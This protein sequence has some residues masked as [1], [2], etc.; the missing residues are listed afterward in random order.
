MKSATVKTSGPE[1]PK[2][3]AFVFRKKEDN[4]QHTGVEP[5]FSQSRPFFPAV[6]RTCSCVDE[7]SVQ[8]QEFP[9]PEVQRNC[10]AEKDEK[11]VQ[12]MSSQEEENAVQHF[13]NEAAESNVQTR[14]IVNEPGD[15]YEQ[16]ANTISEKVMRSETPDREKESVTVSPYTIRRSF[17]DKEKTNCS[18]CQELKKPLV[19]RKEVNGKNYDGKAAPASVSKVI[20]SGSGKSLDIDT[21][22]Y[23]ENRMGHDFSGVKI[24]TDA[25]A[26]ESARAIQAL[27]YTA[28]NHIV[29]N[30]GQYAPATEAG[31]MLLAH[32]LVH[33]IQQGEGVKRQ[34]DTQ[35]KTDAATGSVCDSNTASAEQGAPV[36]SEVKTEIP[37]NRTG[38]KKS[39]VA[40][41]GPPPATPKDQ[42]ADSASEGGNTDEKKPLDSP[43]DPSADPA[44]KEL[45]GDTKKAKK[46]QD[47][48]EPEMAIAEEAMMSAENQDPGGKLENDAKK[49]LATDEK[50][51]PSQ[52][53]NKAA[54]KQ[55]IKDLIQQGLPD[56]EAAN[57][58]FNTNNG[59]GE[60][61]DKSKGNV[62]QSE[63]PTKEALKNTNKA[64]TGSVGN[65]TSLIYKKEVIPAEPESPGKK[66][67]VGSSERAVP[68]P[69]PEAEVQLDEA[70]NADSLDKAMEDENLKEFNTKLTNNQ[71]AD[72]NEPEFMETLA[73][74]QEA[75]V[76]LCQVPTMNREAEAKA[77][78]EESGI[79]QGA[80][81]STM[82]GKFSERGKSIDQVNKG[83]DESKLKDEKMLADYYTKIAGIYDIAQKDVNKRMELLD[84][85]VST[86]FEEAMTSA[87]DIFKSRVKSR[88]D[89]YYGVGVFDLSDEGA[90]ALE[91][92]NNSS[93]EGKVAWLRLQ[94][95]RFPQESDTYKM[96]DS[97]IKE[98]ESGKMETIVD[99]VFREEKD[100]FTQSLDT[101]LDQI[102]DIIEKTF[103]DCKAIITK[104]KEDIKCA[105]QC[106]PTHLQQE[107]TERTD[108][109]ISKF[110]DLDQVLTDKQKD[111]QERL[112]KDYV[113]NVKKLKE[114]FE[115]IRE[116]SA[117]PWWKKAWNA[118][119]KVAMI[120]YDLGKLLLKVLIKAA[121]AIGDIVAHPIRFIGN[122]ISAVGKGFSNFV[123]NIGTHLENIIFKLILGT[124]PP[125][126][127]MPATWDAKGIFS[128]ALDILGLTKENI[129]EKA[130]VKL[131][132]PVVNALEDTFDLF[133]LF[134]KEGF[135]GLWQHIKEKIGDLKDQV[136][137]QIKDYFKDSII[138]AAVKF[139]L[140]CLTPVSGFIKACETLIN[141]ALFFIKNLENILKL[142]D[143]ILDSFIDISKGKVESA[144]KRVEGALADILLI[145]IKFLA[146]LVGINL[147]KI[148]AKI[149]KLFNA[150]RN[151]I[152]RAIT[153]LL[154]K[155]MAFAQ[156]TGLIALVKKGKAK[157]EQGKKWA[158]DKG[159][160][161]VKKG[162]EK[163]KAG[164]ASAKDKIMGW[165]GL[166]KKF[167]AENG[168][169]HELYFSGKGD[170]A[171][172]TMASNKPGAY[173]KWV[174]NIKV[175]T[176]NQAGLARE[177]KKDKAIEVAKEIDILK[178][179][180]T[181]TDEEAETQAADIR[182]K[183]NELSKLT[184]ALMIGLPVCSTDGNGIKF[185]NLSKGGKYGTSM[186]AKQ[187]TKNKMP[188]G[189]VPSVSGNS[190]FNIINQRRHGGGSYY[191]LGHLLN[192]NIGGTGKE[193]ENL[194]PI[195]RV[196]NKQ[197]EYI[198]ESNVKTAVKAGNI[199]Y[200]KVEVEYGRSRAKSKVAKH[201]KIMEE[202]T[203]VPLK[204]ICVADMINPET[205]EKTPL[206]PK[207]TVI[208][209]DVDQSENAYDLTGI[210]YDD[211]F[212]DSGKAAKIATIDGVDMRLAEK[213]VAANR[214]KLKYEGTRFGSYEALAD[215]EF[216]G[217][218]FT[219]KQKATINGL[220]ELSYVKLFKS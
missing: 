136:I 77:Q 213:I 50:L 13:N 37:D 31:K 157:F 151:P 202:E 192:H 87:N 63:N 138:K 171:T 58:S 97:K 161:L 132:E 64:D 49:V 35:A 6:Q 160:A 80:L 135:A 4:H 70:H 105:S 204:F 56:K 93:I 39:S 211:V 156:K 190:S 129:R 117:M 28:G 163:V 165:L 210:K 125:H 205:N 98:L 65:D 194:S 29:F 40:A 115:K 178:K 67:I 217:T 38:G 86:I 126:I 19:L 100:T 137:E 207:G 164:I 147:D 76:Q 169:D 84:T 159:T 124:I 10:A 9:M 82:K 30:K 134:K 118:I 130:V 187:L 154:D 152:N 17:F 21:R 72:S 96:Y 177:K 166:K 140:S 25:Q 110:E 94:R 208:E 212:L 184:G 92:Y 173:E 206:V 20:H 45:T 44:F 162:K 112:A 74:K 128:F 104:G 8:R 33:T 47:E 155:A 102:A 220:Y 121:T 144:A 153:W 75:Q 219:E 68:K 111:I 91:R 179:K 143:S 36:G 23:M 101:A 18:E 119:K 123:D 83:K 168:E 69:V 42:P 148:S 11:G 175:D 103:N 199:V 32:E 89:D 201:D 61:T 127:K 183:M 73:V 52:P 1:S 174:S 60:L 188:D 203:K 141:V 88:L 122:L 139:L 196:A 191:V 41:T 54:F 116:E 51:A 186:E 180:K 149:T 193:W 182:E 170:T 90:D 198:A 106:L 34:A 185:G 55:N 57:K 145:G 79:A 14:L 215:Y 43:K 158:K 22:E 197:H 15:K 24:H 107:A 133:I 172:L 12:R 108:E 113:D 5:F 120:I 48:H 218:V 142:L 114:T 189:S 3:K 95:D 99:R 71:L 46:S 200:Y 62:N 167:T 209:N 27:A 150:I 78:Q 81:N 214:Y 181:K 131:G 176:S 216:D 2:T 16:E 195:T 66:A 59:I 53:F 7:K 146:A 109:F 26:A 85:C